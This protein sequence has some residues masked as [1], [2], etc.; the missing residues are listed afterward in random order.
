MC[1]EKMIS[2]LYCDSGAYCHLCTCK[3]ADGNDVLQIIQ[4]FKMNKTYEDML[5]TWKEILKEEEIKKDK[6]DQ[7]TSENIKWFVKSCSKKHIT[8]YMEI[9]HVIS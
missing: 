8:F 9:L 7:K 3:K 6:K 5:E 2:L 4:G 1:D